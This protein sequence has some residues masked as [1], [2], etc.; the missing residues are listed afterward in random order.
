V[1]VSAGK[2]LASF[3]AGWLW[4]AVPAL[5]IA[6]AIVFWGR[7]ILDEEAML[8]IQKYLA[9]QPLLATI[10]DPND[11]SLYQARELSYLVDIVDAR[12]LAWLFDRG[13]VFLIPLSGAIGLI[14]L[15]WIYL[16]G[17]RQ[18]LQLDRPTSALLLSLLASCIVIQASTPVFYRSAKILLTTLLVAF[19]FRIV[20]LARRRGQGGPIAIGHLVIV[21]LIGFA[22]ALCDRQ[23]FF[24]LLATAVTLVLLWLLAI[25]RREPGAADRVRLAGACAAAIAA[26]TVYGYVVAPWAISTINGTQVTFNYQ[27]RSLTDFDWKLLA[28]GF[29]MFRAQVSYLFGNMPFAAIASIAAAAGVLALRRRL[30][31]VTPRFIVSDGFVVTAALVS[32]PIV[33]LAVMVL[34]HPAVHNIPDHALWYYTITIQALFVFGLTLLAGR[35]DLARR[36]G[37]RRLGHAVLIAMIAS[38]VLHYR[39][40]RHDMIESPYFREQYDRTR[41][42]LENA[43][44]ARE[45]RS[46]AGQRPWLRVESSGAVVSLPIEDE[47]YVEVVRAAYATFRHR[48]P[49]R[50]A[51]G[52]HWSRVYEFLSNS[53]ELLE[54]AESLRSVADGLRSVGVRRVELLPDAGE[55]T[56]RQRAMAEALLS[57]E[58]TTSEVVPGDGLAFGLTPDD[59]P[60][61]S[62][63]RPVPSSAF[64]ASASV[65]EADLARAFDADAGTYWSSGAPQAGDE[66]I[67][68]DFAQPVDVGCVALRFNAANPGRNPPATAAAGRARAAGRAI[69]P[70]AFR[71]QGLVIETQG[72]GRAAAATFNPIAAVIRGLLREPVRPW[73]RLCLPPN[74]SRTLVLRQT[75]R[76]ATD[77]WNVS[78]LT[79][80]E[81]R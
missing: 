48:D 20:S 9:D 66:W 61:P 49:L 13:I 45:G 58:F 52:P 60:V 72:D 69:F 50:S 39:G 55:A 43:D 12:F 74:Q 59:S 67:R 10:F 22:M 78:E 16:R 24:F 80:W 37:A 19:L 42:I 27:Q 5:L 36:P 47:A 56:S 4:Y 14:A 29:E 30:R 33:M 81:R 53:P 51:P 54:D 76:S 35:F 68:I 63:M 21:A 70:A 65:R 15:A 73:M 44:A 77:P 3:N 46:V 1:R 75:G 34:Y 8:Y 11:A 31:P 32:A 41:Q 28:I 18:V 57:A 2:K 23:G 79:I 7:G 25:V 64:D 38:N 26:A 40:Q 62:S 6:H 17:A 71:P